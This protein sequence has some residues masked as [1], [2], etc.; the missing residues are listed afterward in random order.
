MEVGKINTNNSNSK[1]PPPD[2]FPWSHFASLAMHNLINHWEINHVV[3]T[4]NYV[5]KQSIVIKPRPKVNN[6][7]FTYINYHLLYTNSNCY[8]LIDFEVVGIEGKIILF[9]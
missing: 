5:Q 1:G 6:H 2:D 9:C 4:H 3:E 7:L 8:K